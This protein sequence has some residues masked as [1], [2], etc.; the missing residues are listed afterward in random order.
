MKSVLISISN[1]FSGLLN[2]VNQ[3]CKKKKIN[4]LNA[5]EVVAT[6]ANTMKTFN[7]DSDAKKRELE[8]RTI[9]G[10]R[11]STRVNV[12]LLDLHTFTKAI[13]KDVN[14]F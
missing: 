12:N 8:C 14:V 9:Y 1:H 3:C 10:Q 11:I 13:C 5:V 2:S 7:A 4:L 6:S